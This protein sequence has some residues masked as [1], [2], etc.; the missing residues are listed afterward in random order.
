MKPLSNIIPHQYKGAESETTYTIEKRTPKEAR[1]LYAK[2]KANLLDVNHWH[3]LAGKGSADF[4]LTDD[5]GNPLTG[6]VKKGNYFRIN[7]KTVLPGDDKYDWVK[8][9]DIEEGH[10]DGVSDWTIVKVRPTEKPHE[11][12]GEVTHFFSAAATSNF[13]VKR[14]RHKVTAAVLGKNEIPNVEVK[15]LWVKIRNA[16]IGLAG[17][18]GFNK[19]QW[20]R[21]VKGILNK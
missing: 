13:F 5:E 10:I 11:Y 7:I 21:L 6:T 9:E 12:K 3:D 16:L 19:S 17:M 14:Q 18:I 1:M 2:A 8:V 15:S 20:K 4:Q